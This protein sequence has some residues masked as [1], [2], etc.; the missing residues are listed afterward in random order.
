MNERLVADT[1]RNVSADL[2]VGLPPVDDVIRAGE[3]RARNRRFGVVAAA[4]T[5]VA[6]IAGT[7]GLVGDRTGQRDSLPVGV[8]KEENPLPMPWWGDGVL[9]LAHVTVTAQGVTQVLALPDG[10]AYGTVAGKVVVVDAQ[11]NR[12]TVGHNPFEA[13]MASGTEENWLAWVDPRDKAPQLV[14]Y[15]V[16]AEAELGRVDLPYK[17]ARWERLDAG[18]HP[19]AIDQGRVYYATQDGDWSWSPGDA[20]PRRET[21]HNLDLADVQGGTRIWRAWNPGQGWSGQLSLSRPGLDDTSLYPSAGSGH[22]SPDGLHL[23]VGG[24]PGTGIFPVGSHDVV[25]LELDSVRHTSGL[26]FRFANDD[27]VVAVAGGQPAPP[28]TEEPGMGLTPVF[29]LYE[30]WDLVTCHIGS[31][32][33]TT[34]RDATTKAAPILPS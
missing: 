6:I 18:S 28:P 30:T 29:A 32:V 25:E 19:I 13:P 3:R 1:L 15:D 33:C 23:V 7:A 22:L 14:V 2:P 26:Q 16:S 31:E 20:E 9:H 8:V 4:A 24:G 10:A 11:G 12:K 21:P 27:T 34:I 5:S 17:G